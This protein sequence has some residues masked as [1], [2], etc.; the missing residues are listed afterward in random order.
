MPAR[1][2]PFYGVFS[3]SVDSLTAVLDYELAPEL[4]STTTVSWGDA[5]VERCPARP[6]TDAD[7][8]QGL[9]GRGIAE[10]GPDESVQWL[11]GVH[12]LGS[13]LDQFIN[14]SAVLGRATSLTDRRASVC[15]AK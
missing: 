6:G 2:V 14:L 7:A 3:N 10:L 13:N 11:G 5:F 1:I 15:S 4:S 9:L 8:F 12:Y